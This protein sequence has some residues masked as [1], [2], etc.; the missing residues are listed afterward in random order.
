MEYME[1][2]IKAP[3]IV[4]D[5]DPHD[6]HQEKNIIILVLVLLYLILV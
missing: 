1:E 3:L 5:V 4:L 2:L 6:G